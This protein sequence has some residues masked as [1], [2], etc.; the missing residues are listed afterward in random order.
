[1]RKNKRVRAIEKLYLYRMCEYNFLSYEDL[2]KVVR[3]RFGGDYSYHRM[4]YIMNNVGLHNNRNT[5]F[6]SKIRPYGRLKYDV[7]QEVTR[8]NGY[9]YV[10]IDNQTWMPKH[11]LIWEKANNM[12]MP[13]DKRIAFLDGDNSNLSP[14][15]LVAIGNNTLGYAN[16]T[17]KRIKGDAEYNKS[18]YLLSELTLKINK[19]KK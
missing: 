18:I 4:R 11:Q 2:L 1:M 16:R 13:E 5:K 17:F 10:K 8:T 19:I 15:N 14:D 6:G 3:E 7:G 12:K 9:T